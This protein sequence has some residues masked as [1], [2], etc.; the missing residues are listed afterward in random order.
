MLS[1]FCAAGCLS[2]G[3]S[4]PTVKSA[5]EVFPNPSGQNITIKFPSE[6]KYLCELNIIDMTGKTVYTQQL[7]INN[8]GPLT[9]N[10]G[11]LK[12]GIY[13]LEISGMDKLIR[14]KLIRN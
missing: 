9:I 11:Y 4:T 5:V 6:G 8:G 14:Q 2:T 3:T 13:V 1:K 12:A 10:P 7:N